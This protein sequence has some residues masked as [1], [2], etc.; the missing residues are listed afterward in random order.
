MT[1]H[2]LTDL[3][4]DKPASPLA[5]LLENATPTTLAAL[6][7]DMI[8]S[9]DADTAELATA[10]HLTLIALV[11]DDEALRLVGGEP[12]PRENDVAVAAFIGHIAKARDYVETIQQALDDHFD[13]LP[14]KVD[15]GNVG[16]A[17][18]VAD[19]LR[20]A[21]QFITGDDEDEEE[22]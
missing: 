14:E 8:E 22:E 7:N 6:Y 2:T 3:I 21:A 5:L 17:A 19:L 1:T 16:D 18:H 12:E 9:P 11:G 4:N 13:T 15:W 20:Q 10:I